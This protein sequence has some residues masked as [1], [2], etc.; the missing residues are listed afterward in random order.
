[1]VSQQDYALN[2]PFERLPIG[3]NSTKPGQN[4]Q[5]AVT[6]IETETGLIFADAVRQAD[7]YTG[8]STG[9]QL[10]TVADVQHPR[11]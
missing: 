8:P 5:V 6:K 1:M 7:V 11:R 3:P 2:I 9:R 4:F 10:R